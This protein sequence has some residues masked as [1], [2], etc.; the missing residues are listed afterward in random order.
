MRLSKL[1]GKTL[2][3]DPKDAKLV[4]HKFL[5][6]G[7]YIRQVGAGIYSL[8]PI[9]KRIVAKIENIIRE[10]MNRI[11]GQEVLLPVVMPREL[12][13]EAGRY[14]SIGDEMLRFKDRN[15]NDM[16]LGMTHEE[17]IVHLARTEINSYKQLPVMLYQIQT[18]FRDETRSRGG[19]IRVREFTMKD[20]YSFHTSF[21]DMV[22][23]YHKVHEA[24][25]R[26]FK[27]TGLVEFIDVESDA[28]MMGGNASHE[29]MLLT[30]DGEDA[31]FLCPKCKYRANKEIAQADYPGIEEN[32]KPLKKVATPG[33]K[34]IEEV[35]AFLKVDKQQTAKAV[36]YV[37]EEDQLVFV[38]IRGDLEVNENKLGKALQTN[39]FRPAHDVEIEQAG[40]VPGYASPLALSTDDF[41]LVVDP[42]V[43]QS[44]N[45]VTG[46]NQIDAHYMNFN[47]NRD[48][49]D[50]DYIQADIATP[51]EGDPC[52]QCNQPLKSNRGIEIG[53]IFQLGTK[54]S[55][56]MQADFLNEHGKRKPAVM[57]CYGIGVGRLMASVIEEKNDEYGPVWPL[58]IAPWQV[59]ICA[60]NY[61]KQKV[62]AATEKLYNDLKEAGIDVL[63]D[64]RDE[65]AGV[66]FN[67]ADLRGIPFR[68]VISPRN[69]KKNQVEFK[70]RDSKDK[71]FIPLNKV[72]ETLSLK[73]KQELKKYS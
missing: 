42:T 40:A 50:L 11:E 26:I 71:A 4:S 61:K 24:Y 31:V 2:R 51:R 46:A 36:F 48:L 66:Q 70:R 35:A 8:L 49:K 18:K 57:G 6:R 23:Y 53:N 52:P 41:T 7:A 72:V 19:L 22:D 34:T 59:Q 58:S 67:D 69:L 21:E 1:I 12:W 14:D 16:L 44:N 27:R 3:D 9:A 56:P 43:E 5:L 54:Y 39:N 25:V 30:P 15:N 45:L 55:E 13:E 20:A 60:I 17:A 73:I 28:G 68:I 10:E 29:F 62:K 37:A 33:K 32:S 64:D 47:T 38:L 65:K 63:L